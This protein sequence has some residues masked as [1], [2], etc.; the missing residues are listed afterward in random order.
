MQAK[1]YPAGMHPLDPRFR[2]V[3]ESAWPRLAALDEPVAAQ[4]L[5][6]GGWS[7]KQILGHL[8]DSASNN[9]QRFVRCLLDGGL[10][11][12]PS[13]EQNGWVETGRYQDLPW[14]GLVEFW[15]GYNRLLHHILS[16]LPEEKFALRCQVGDE[17]RS[18]GELASA[19][20]DHLEH[21]L[22]RILG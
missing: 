7:R 18:L 4:P 11:A 3:I 6:T 16:H 12:W 17:N 14:T 1:C 5:K 15:S 20:L 8:I 19:Y 10:T 21:H 22:N 2:S 9:H 13:Y